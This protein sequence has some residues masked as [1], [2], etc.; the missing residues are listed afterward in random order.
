MEARVQ[1]EIEPQE[2]SSKSAQWQERRPSKSYVRY[3][4]VNKCSTN[5]SMQCNEKKM[6]CKRRSLLTLTYDA[7]LALLLHHAFHFFVGH[8][9]PF[10]D[11]G[12]P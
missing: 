2:H 6:R 7:L 10:A 3:M 9:L 12:V 8:S 11:S 1:S 4:H 5:E